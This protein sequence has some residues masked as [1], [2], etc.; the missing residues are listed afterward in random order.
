MVLWPDASSRIV[1]V[2]LRTG[3][4]ILEFTVKHVVALLSAPQLSDKNWV[5]ISLLGGD[6]PGL[7]S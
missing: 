7:A 2:K 4:V 5:R 1:L 3:R 6:R